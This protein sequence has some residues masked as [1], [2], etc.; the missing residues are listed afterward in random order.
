VV[1]AKEFAFC[2][3]G[4]T[5]LAD[6]L[7]ALDTY[8]VSRFIF[9][10][11]A[12]HISTQ[13]PLSSIFICLIKLTHFQ[14]LQ[15]GKFEFLAWTRG[16]CRG[17]WF[18]AKFLPCGL[19]LCCRRL[20]RIFAFFAF[21]CSAIRKRLPQAFEKTFETK[22]RAFLSCLLNQVSYLF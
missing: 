14:L 12:L 2:F 5:N 6:S 7:T 8:S 13:P 15:K 16:S 17:S 11:V 20:I 19:G 3:L 4:C 21:D 22:Y 10:R 9:M 18:P 1:L